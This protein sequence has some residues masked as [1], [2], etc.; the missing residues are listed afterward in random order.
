MLRQ[1]LLALSWISHRPI[2]QIS[3]RIDAISWMCTFCKREWMISSWFHVC[4]VTFIGK[5]LQIIECTWLPIPHFSLCRYIV[6]KESL[7]V[8]SFLIFGGFDTQHGSI[9]AIV[10]ERSNHQQFVLVFNPNEITSRWFHNAKSIAF[11]R[12][13]FG[14]GSDRR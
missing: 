11:F 13:H 2:F 8:S 1:K 7:F 3:E 10:I 12:S 4:W 9:W 5:W 14:P 6:A